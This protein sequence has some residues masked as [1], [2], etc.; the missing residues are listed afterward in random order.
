MKHL[1][2]SSLDLK[3]T[4]MLDVQLLGLMI[5]IHQRFSN[6]FR[7]RTPKLTPIRKDMPETLMKEA[8][9]RE[10]LREHK[11]FSFTKQ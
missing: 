10:K 11:E 3:K 4:F 6:Y 1:Q 9:L 7:W 2:S 8:A 5:K